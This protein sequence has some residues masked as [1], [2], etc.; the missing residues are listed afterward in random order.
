MMIGELRANSILG[1]RRD[2]T[3]ILMDDIAM[4]AAA[5]ARCVVHWSDVAEV[6][7]NPLF[8]YDGRAVTVDAR[9]VLSLP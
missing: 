8:A 1:R 5:I 3:D 7:V 9:V 4:A 6:E 2:P